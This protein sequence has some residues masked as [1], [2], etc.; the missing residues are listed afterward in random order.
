MKGRLLLAASMA[1]AAPTL[2][3]DLITGESSH[4]GGNL[5]GGMCSFSTYTLPEG[6]FGTA[7]SGAAWQ[8]SGVCGACLEVTGPNGNT[9]KAMVCHVQDQLTAPMLISPSGR[10]PMPR[11]P[12]E[13]ARPLHGRLCT[14][15]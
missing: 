14:A 2:G 1:G 12:R 5:N 9:I 8:D 10:R 6:T 13:Q 3:G 11:V 4:Y 7:F 15:R